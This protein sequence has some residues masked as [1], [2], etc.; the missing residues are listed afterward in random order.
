M[1]S[2]FVVEDDEAI[3]SLLCMNLTVT[4]YRVESETDG[5]R[6]KARIESGEHYDLGLL[7]VMLPGVD[8]F[9]LLETF[10]AHKIP[11]IFLTAKNHVNDRV[12]GL[13]DGAEDYIVKPFELME[14][15]VRVEKVLDRYAPAPKDLVLGD[16][17]MH[18]DSR[19]VEKGGEP[20]EL[21]PTQYDLLHLLARN[22]NVALSRETILAEVW[23]SDF[24]G[25]S[26]TIDNHISQ[27]RKRTGLSIVSVSRVGYRL[28]LD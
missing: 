22:R 18:L 8:G 19:T 9:T 10:R 17:V 26:R 25:E 4:G 24:M 13:R 7:D 6:A 12:R 15:L 21:T 14:L 20:I 1:R 27:L 16:V 28:E 2:I 3:N 5:Q 11:V 23:N